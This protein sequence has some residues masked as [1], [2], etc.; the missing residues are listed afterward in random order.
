LRL[1]AFFSLGTMRET[2]SA[3][4]RL[5]HDC[6]FARVTL[7]ALCTLAPA[8]D[9]PSSEKIELWKG[10]ERGPGKLRNAVRSSSVSPALRGEAL[11]AEAEI[12]MVD[13]IDEDLRSLSQTQQQAVIHEALPRLFRLMQGN[14][15]TAPPTK[16]ARS[17]KDVTFL[18]RQYAQPAD[19]QLIDDTLI[20]WVLVDLGGR[21]QAG[22]VGA[23]KIFTAAGTRAGPPLV[24][25]ASQAGSSRNVACEIL[26][27]LGDPASREQASA[28]L[29]ELA[30]KE[31][32]LREDTIRCLG[33]LGA[34]AGIKFLMDIAKNADEDTRG[35]AMGALRL[36]PDPAALPFAL[37]LAKDRKAPGIAREG[38]FSLCETIGGKPVVDGL[39]P[40]LGDPDTKVA[41]R[42]LEAVLAAGKSDAIVPALERTSARLF[43][44]RADVTDFLVKDLVRIGPTA[45]PVLRRELGSKNPVARVA[46]VMALGDLGGKAEADVVGKLTNDGARLGIKGF[47]GA[48]TVGAEAKA[49][50]EKLRR[51]G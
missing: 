13:E 39:L 41:L 47:G 38:A 4:M 49:V 44:E 23:E 8:C 25:L 12:G 6:S 30:R 9:S 51:K 42:A 50:V 22:N 37:E 15:P 33:Q 1:R 27:R 28:R 45:L 29:A 32:P 34:P 5:N 36:H 11:A 35:N 14:D 31:T 10:T 24:P 7:L 46:A 40:L 2:K 26:G 3:L 17:A 19:Q 18:V 43:K 16:A 21:A 20:K 48:G